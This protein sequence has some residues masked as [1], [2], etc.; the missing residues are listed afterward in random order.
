M[1]DIFFCCNR[2]FYNRLKILGHMFFGAIV[3][4]RL[5]RNRLGHVQDTRNRPQ[6]SFAIVSDTQT[7][8]FLQPRPGRAEGRSDCEI[9][10]REQQSNVLLRREARSCCLIACRDVQTEE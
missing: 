6:S 4:N 3:S 5:L 10:C 2:L 1:L 8:D 7:S 9:T